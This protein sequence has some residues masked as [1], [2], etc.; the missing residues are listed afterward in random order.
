MVIVGSFSSFC[1]KIKVFAPGLC[2]CTRKKSQSLQKCVLP[3][4]QTLEVVF[5][6]LKIGE[7]AKICYSKMQNSCS[8]FSASKWAQELRLG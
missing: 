2:E 4:L 7:S 1:L 8:H 6:V 5:I 3:G